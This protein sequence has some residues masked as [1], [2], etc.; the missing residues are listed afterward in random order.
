[1]TPAPDG[2]DVTNE[3]ISIKFWGVRGTVSCGGP[4]TVG[5]GGN[6]SCV[7][8]RCGTTLLIFDAG[9]G[10]RFLG[11]E[12]AARNEAV[13]AHILLTHTHLDHILGLPFFRPAYP[14]CN[15]LQLWNG[16]LRR[17]GETLQNVLSRIMGDPFFPVP[18]DIMHGCIAFNDFDAGA[19]LDLGHGIS[20]RTMP[21]NHPGGS[22][23]YRLDYGGRSFSYVTDTEHR[24][25]ERDQAIVEFIRGSDLVVYDATYTDEEFPRFVGWGHST[26][27]EGIRLCEAAGA[28]RV[29]AFHHSPDHDDAML[30]AIDEA[31]N[32]ARPGSFVARERLEIV[33]G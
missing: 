1:M 3:N 20:I 15:Q 11:R 6:T 8:V 21:L 22:T 27:Q 28:A 17:R 29:A 24:V 25:G 14:A 2:P 12:L 33:L 23:A 32:E 4:E 18:L 16:H 31:M 9:T 13:D 5:Y 7:E 19:T 26:W 30:A 10:L